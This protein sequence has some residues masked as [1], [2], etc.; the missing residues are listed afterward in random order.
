MKTK[1]S[2]WQVNKAII[3]AFVG[4]GIFGGSL[5]STKAN[6][7]ALE[8]NLIGAGG[9][10]SLSG[11][12]PPN[13]GSIVY[14]FGNTPK[15]AVF[16]E[17]VC[18]LEAPTLSGSNPFLKIKLNGSYVEAV[19]GRGLGRLRNKGLF[20]KVGAQVMAPWY[21]P[22]GGWRVLY[23]PDF[24]A[25]PAIYED[26]PYR[27]LIDITDL[28]VIGGANSI[29]LTNTASL[30]N[31]QPL[32][33]GECRII[34]DKLA[35]IYYP[36]G[37]SQMT[38]PLLT[39]VDYLNEGTPAKGTAPYVGEV[40]NGGG[41]IV[42]V[43]SQV[44]SFTSLFSYPNAGFNVLRPSDDTDPSGEPGW[45]VT[46]SSLTTGA[47]VVAEG[48]RY[49][50]RREVNFGV[51]K[52]TII[53]TIENKT[54]SPLG[55]MVRNE[56][57]LKGAEN[58][59]V[60]LA[61][62]G[63]SSIVDSS[64]ASG[65]NV[66]LVNDYYAPGNPTIFVEGVGHGIG[67]I[68][69]DIVYRYQARLYIRPSDGYNDAG[70]KTDVGIPTA[71]IKTEMMY[72]PA[73]GTHTMQWSV[74]P[75][76]GDMAGVDYFDFV[77]LVREDLGVNAIKTEGPWYWAMSPDYFLGMTNAE[78]KS[79][80]E[81]KGIRYAVS[82]GG[83]LDLTVPAIGPRPI[84]F[85]AAVFEP[86]WDSFR[87]RL[88]N[89][90]DKIHSHVEDCQVLVYYNAQRD[91]SSSGAQAFTDS[92][93]TAL[94]G[95]SEYTDWGGLYTRTYSY[96]PVTGDSYG[97]NAFG[98][99]MQ[100]V[101]D[102]C[103]TELHADGIYWDE[104]ENVTYGTPSL[105]YNRSDGV[106]CLINPNTF[107]ISSGTVALTA[108]LSEEFQLS[109]IDGVS[110]ATP[111]H[112][113]NSVMLG[114]GPT[115]S[116]D[117]LA[118]GIQRMVE[119]QHNDFWP[120]EGHFQTPLGYLGGAKDFDAIQRL[121]VFG[122]LPVGRAFATYDSDAETYKIMPY[123][124]PFTPIEL[125]MGYLFGQER[126]IVSHKGNFGWPN[127][128]SMV[129]VRYFDSNGNPQAVD[130][131]TM[132]RT[133]GNKTQVTLT[134]QTKRNQYSAPLVV[135]EKLPATVS[136]NGTVAIAGV[137]YE[138]DEFRFN[139]YS[140]SGTT[141]TLKGGAF[142]LS[143][144]GEYRVTST[145]LSTGEISVI[146]GQAGG[147]ISEPTLIIPLGAREVARQIKITKF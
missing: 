15:T 55:L 27:L 117:T 88:V 87:S 36:E 54:A 28:I 75:V 76:Q 50:V 100:T 134:S 43:G 49:E 129:R 127:D 143:Y 24:V 92:V 109:V 101:A 29:E 144:N 6:E 74:Y 90:I 17:V 86:Y 39:A 93:K 58:A 67:M 42:Q 142:T 70:V 59:P 107:S 103:M 137:S 112:G 21:Y 38:L 105:T 126:I 98:N 72:L 7:A 3:V 32:I 48:G 135:L 77:N 19:K 71:G 53:D 57:S 64:G 46:T 31:L 82:G 94:N 79:F 12:I 123:L 121:L 102:R 16:L 11:K 63:D 20:A 125:H 146:T 44:W 108:L 131:N 118:T 9:N 96:V 73:F 99:A 91:T 113:G 65:A 34:V 147:S 40:K 60:R 141:V 47:D 68:A 5:S 1:S 18:R 4:I 51:H 136:P 25:R 56:V 120:S 133:D 45:S 95:A 22:S 138:P 115:G 128:N 10:L 83:W 104:F 81:S 2:K 66:A 140:P 78:V 23:S 69:D 114:N 33:G 41:F 139:V 61:G 111:F 8:I 116:L 13:N 132:V 124:F 62:C 80:F 14:S 106:S 110:T 97:D 122:L 26:N 52:V 30:S 35:V 84:G 37:R 145:V 89:A 130:Y 119:A 85:G